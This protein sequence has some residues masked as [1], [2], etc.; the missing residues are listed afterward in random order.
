MAQVSNCH[1]KLSSY[2][3]SSLLPLFIAAKNHQTSIT[4]LPYLRKVHNKNRIR[5]FIYHP[6]GLLVAFFLT[7]ATLK[8]ENAQEIQTTRF[9]CFCGLC[10]SSTAFTVQY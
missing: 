8:Q 5:L 9:F 1:F 6:L 2:T 3:E 10:L 4:K 7:C